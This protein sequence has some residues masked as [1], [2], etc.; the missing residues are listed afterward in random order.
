[1]TRVVFCQISFYLCSAA[2][3]GC[4]AVFTTWLAWCSRGCI[5][6]EGSW[7]DMMCAVNQVYSF[8]GRLE[9]VCLEHIMKPNKNCEGSEPLW[10]LGVRLV[11]SIFIMQII[12]SHFGQGHIFAIFVRLP[13]IWLVCLIRKL[14][15]HLLPWRGRCRSNDVSWEKCWN[16][17]KLGGSLLVAHYLS[18]RFLIRCGMFGLS[19]LPVTSFQSLICLCHR[20][21]V[22]LAGNAQCFAW[23]R[24]P[25]VGV[26]QE[27]YLIC[28]CFLEKNQNRNYCPMLRTAYHFHIKSLY[29]LIF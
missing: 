29:F 23:W 24:W 6:A 5:L 22:T 4:S 25:W 11:T 16:K 27:R 17:R 13:G 20:V 10:S 28:N 2:D 12:V 7:T 9:T 19:S 14:F 26:W 15:A 18:P 21:P 8:H 3:M 1:M